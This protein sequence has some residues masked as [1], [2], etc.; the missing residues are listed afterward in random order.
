MIYHILA[1]ISGIDV[2]YGDYASLS[3]GHRHSVL[4][5]IRRRQEMNFS[6][7]MVKRP[8]N[9][10]ILLKF[11]QIVRLERIH[12]LCNLSRDT[13]SR[14]LLCFVTVESRPRSRSKDLRL[15]F[16]LQ[17]LRKL[18]FSKEAH[19]PN[20]RLNVC[21][22]H[23]KPLSVRCSYVILEILNDLFFSILQFRG[24]ARVSVH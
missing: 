21:K 22:H 4:L 2:K 17:L 18:R 15:K 19:L 1:A 23:L 3:R 6:Y 12:A 13:L 24:S 10:S 7:S 20:R 16:H 9:L 11:T 5:L 8:I 14:T